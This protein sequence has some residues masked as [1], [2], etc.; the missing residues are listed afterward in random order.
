MSIA[1]VVKK[2]VDS[3]G[4]DALADERRFSSFVDDMVSEN[5]VEKNIVK[6]AL[7][8]GIYE[9]FLSK[10]ES[11]D[12]TAIANAAVDYLQKNLGITEEWAAFAAQV[13]ADALGWGITVERKPKSAPEPPP[14]PAPSQPTPAPKPTSAPEPAQPTPM[15]TSMPASES[16]PDQ[17]QGQSNKKRKRNYIKPALSYWI[18]LFFCL[19]LI[20]VVMDSYSEL[21][22]VVFIIYIVVLFLAIICVCLVEFVVL[23][24]KVINC[25]AVVIIILGIIYFIISIG[26]IVNDELG[27]VYFL[28]SG[29]ICFVVQGI[30]WLIKSGA[31]NKK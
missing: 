27:G 6:Q 14:A 13:F 18:L 7:N 19:S 16:L 26:F 2:Y 21:F 4:F 3:Y 9:R 17:A 24:K 29:A 30:K 22:A 1:D 20:E 11:G 5:G 12:K 28:L 10:A 8:A 15:P 31:L 25:L 23:E